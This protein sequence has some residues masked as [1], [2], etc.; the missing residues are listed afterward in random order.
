MLRTMQRYIGLRDHAAAG[1]FFVH[2]RYTPDL[3]FLKGAA[4]IIEIH[5]GRGCHGRR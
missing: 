4:A 5:V 2:H 3:I 1:T